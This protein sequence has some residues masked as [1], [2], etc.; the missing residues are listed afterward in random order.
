MSS[1]GS[2]LNLKLLP[3]LV[4]LG[5]AVPLASTWAYVPPSS[6]IIKSTA[7][8]HGGIKGVKVRSQVTVMEGE[9]PGSV[10]F[11]AITHYNPS[12]GVL[13]AYAYDERGQ[14]LYAVERRDDSA[15]PAD[16]LLFWR[17]ENKVAA[18]LKA[19]GI[20]IR[21]EDEL[22]K[23]KDEDERRLS[24]NSRLARWNSAT[25]WVIGAPELASPQVWIEKDT[26]LPLRLI[27][28]S[29]PD[30]GASDLVDLQFEGQRHHREFPFPRVIMAVQDKQLLFRDEVQDI[31]IT[32]DAAEFRAAVTPGFTEAGN[33]SPG[34][35]RDLIQKYFEVLR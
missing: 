12:T 9:K 13:R 4:F 34:S 24:E 19:R 23:M 32:L 15:T 22:G 35:L 7:A 5:A 18:V 2:E 16:A 28:A 33:S 1:E 17:D 25:A 11:K 29:R 3:A 10:R 21:T 26:F 6:F 14:K 30:A 8:K 20:P 31:S 27:A